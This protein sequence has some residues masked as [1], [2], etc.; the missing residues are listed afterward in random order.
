M[1]GAPRLGGAVALLLALCA[2]APAAAGATEVTR[3]ELAALAERAR[4]DDAALAELREV[5]RVDGRPYA[6]EDALAGAEGERLDDRLEEI[7]ALDGSADGAEP[8][9][10]QGDAQ[11]ILDGNRYEG[12]DV[13]RPFKGVLDEIGELLDPIGEWIEE[14]FD[15]VARAVPGGD[16]TLWSLTAALILIV[17]LTLGRRT[18]R[19]RAKAGSER[20]TDA[21]APQREAPVSLERAAEEAERAGELEKALRLRFRAGLLRL[22]E[23]DAIQFRPSISTRE[24]SRALRSPEFD[25]LAALFDGVAYGGERAT[26]EDLDASRRGWDAVLRGAGR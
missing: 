13:P 5:D 21:E 3:A 8:G 11:D 14:A 22:D 1:R 17:L 19:A 16:A 20:R 15:D 23:R 12:S 26:R 25:Q 9:G 6:I 7:A 18:L 4:T 2:A 24:V 10:A